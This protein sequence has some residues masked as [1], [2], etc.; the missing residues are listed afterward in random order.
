MDPWVCKCG[1]EAVLHRTTNGKHEYLCN[2]CIG[3]EEY[4]SRDKE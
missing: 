3:E 1:E 4:E 2:D